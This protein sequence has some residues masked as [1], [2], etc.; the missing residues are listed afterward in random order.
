MV[1]PESVRPEASVIVTEI[2]TGMRTPVSS[3]TC[4]MAKS[5]A[6]EFKVSKIVSTSSVSTPAA[7]SARM[8]ASSSLRLSLAARAILSISA[9]Q[10]A[11]KR[12]LARP[13]WSATAA[14][15]ETVATL[16]TVPPVRMGRV[17]LQ[18]VRPAAAV[19]MAGREA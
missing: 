7:M 15:P 3:K 17:Y 5:A 4:S 12:R 11:S 18:T 1:C 2:I 9:R 19:A 8:V 13:V 10:A 16:A 14:T 6:L